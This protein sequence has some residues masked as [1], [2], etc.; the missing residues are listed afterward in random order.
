MSSTSE[1][2][3]ELFGRLH[4]VLVH[5]PLAL[6][7]A[8]AL[9]EL[10]RRGRS[11]RTRSSSAF[12]CLL[13]GWVSALVTASSG[14]V[15]AEHDPARGRLAETLELHRWFGVAGVSA[16]TLAV[17]LGALARDRTGR[18]LAA[19]RLALL[20]SAIA[21]GVGG[22]FGGTL[23]H[24]RG[25][26]LRPFE[27]D[28]RRIDEGPAADGTAPVPDLASDGVADA[29]ARVDYE[30]DVRPILAASCYECHGP[31]KAKA[32]LRLNDMA[33]LFA[34]GAAD[35]LLVP[36][37]PEESELFVRVNLPPDD[38]DHM[39]EEGESLTPA[40]IATLRAWIEQGA[41]GWQGAAP[42]G[43]SPEPGTER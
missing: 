5:F 3:L 42:S 39:P 15:L 14:W 25:F 41:G 37:K 24:G 34:F 7:V 20:A 18:L 6:I 32:G 4:V 19:Y 29:G 12:S 2:L 31:D 43:A 13:L 30:R 10:L 40:Q 26:L 21:V 28:G 33:E 9:F 38:I 27:R 16:A 11:E 36:G 1:K 8:A 22:H 17:L 23:V 35:W